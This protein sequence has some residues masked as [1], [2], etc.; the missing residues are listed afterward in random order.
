MSK[1]NYVFNML[2]IEYKSIKDNVCF[3]RRLMGETPIKLEDFNGKLLLVNEDSIAIYSTRNAAK[4]F[5]VKHSASGG[6]M[7]HNGRQIVVYDC[8]NGNINMYD[9]FTKT[10]SEQNK[11]TVYDVEIANDGK[12]AVIENSVHYVSNVRIRSKDGS[13]KFEWH[14]DQGYVLRAAFSNDA[15]ELLMV[16]LSSLGGVPG[17]RVGLFEIE[18]GKM[19]S[20]FDTED[21]VYHISYMAGRIVVITDS[22]VY[23]LN[24]ELQLVNTFAF[25]GEEL[26][27]FD[28]GAGLV[29]LCFKD[30]S[31]GGSLDVVSLDSGGNKLGK[32]KISGGELKSVKCTK[33]NIG[34]LTDRNILLFNKRLEM[35]K[36]YDCKVPI[37]DFVC[38]DNHMFVVS[39]RELIKLK[40]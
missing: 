4:L 7:N 22:N 33:N 5:D 26:R 39:D 31:L 9:K 24:S 8:V 27:V 35:M 38:I 14:V 3:P 16:S 10:N 34:I 37:Y 1:I 17:Y 18:S 20:K 29:V 6:G 32:V 21:V 30:Y 12:T 23:F 15:Q 40:I 36:S 25:D 13:H 2:S 11:G 19:K 28:C